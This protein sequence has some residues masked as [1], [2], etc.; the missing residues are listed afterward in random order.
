MMIENGIKTVAVVGAGVIGRSWIHVFSR[1]GCKTRVYDADGTKAEAAFKWVKNDLKCDESDGLIDAESVKSR[2]ALISVHADLAEALDTAEYVQE[3]GP[4]SLDIKQGIFAQM[5]E[6]SPPGVILASSTSALD[7]QDIAGTLKGADR[8][9]AAHPFNPPHILPAVE[10]MPTK[11]VNSIL[12]EKILEFLQNVGQKPVKMNFFMP[13]YIANRIQSAV[14]R[15]AIH[16]VES[17]AADV[18]AVDTVISDALGLRWVLFGN[19]GT[20][21][22]NA[23]GG[24]REYFTRYGASYREEMETLDPAPPSFD[25][26]MIERIGRQVDLKEGTAPISDICRWRDQMILKILKLKNENPHP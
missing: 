11:A 1:A 20:N 9:F 5:D 8:C 24:I 4:E 16:L 14:V 2:L 12:F 10:V 7:I 26:E 22:T 15:E 23:D 19:F 6:V 21:N 17:G 3:S 18:E 25:A 13:G